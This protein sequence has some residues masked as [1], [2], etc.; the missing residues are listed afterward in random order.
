MKHAV[1]S[2]KTVEV[3]ASQSRALWLKV[4]PFMSLSHF[5]STKLQIIKKY[6]QF[7][8]NLQLMLYICECENATVV[9]I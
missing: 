8:N 9:I 1:P 7:S 6:A 2:N 5:F 3:L 4:V